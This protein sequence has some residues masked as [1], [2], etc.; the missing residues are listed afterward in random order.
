MRTYKDAGCFVEEHAKVYKAETQIPASLIG[1]YLEQIVCNHTT[2]TIYY[3]NAMGA[4]FE[5]PRTPPLDISARNYVEIIWRAVSGSR[6][7]G[8]NGRID[9]EAWK[10]FL[11]IDYD[12]MLEGPVYIPEICIVL[13]TSRHAGTMLN[14]ASSAYRAALV[15]DLYG[16]VAEEAVRSPVSIMANDPTGIYPYL[17]TIINGE[18]T[19]VRVTHFAGHDETDDIVLVRRDRSAKVGANDVRTK[20]T[21]FAD[22]KRMPEMMWV[23]DGYR[24][25][26]HREKLED[27]LKQEKPA[28][29][30]SLIP[31]SEHRRI[32]EQ[33]MALREELEDVYKKRI[34]SDKLEIDTLKRERDQATSER[35]SDQASVLRMEELTAQREKRI[36]DVTMA[37]LAAEEKQREWERER[38]DQAAK[39]AAEEAKRHYEEKMTKQKSWYDTLKTIGPA[40]VAIGGIIAGS[41]SLWK[42]LLPL[43]GK[44]AVA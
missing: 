29:D 34:A 32:L 9:G 18:V 2:E 20:K 37:Q 44:T 13:S 16:K 38:I 5:I 23:I 42:V 40:L 24:I 22:L 39:H 33:E 3:T 25:S 43:I 31:M 6:V 10:Y 1:L 21:S 8:K 41:L 35:Y 11:N 12:K 7:I 17:Y 26:P 4:T 27:W 19:C 14:P 36:H 15:R 28:V 30:P